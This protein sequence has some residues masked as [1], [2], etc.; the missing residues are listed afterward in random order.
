LAINFRHSGWNQDRQRVYDALH[1]TGQ[2]VA[3]TTAFAYCG[4]H[5]YVLK[6]N[7]DPPR[8]KLAGSG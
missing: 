3:R 7:D 4:A 2:S 1:R 6:S 5:T 8:Y